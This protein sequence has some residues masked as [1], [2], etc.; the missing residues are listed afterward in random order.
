M[1]IKLKK[2]HCSKNRRLG[3]E[4][5]PTAQTFQISCDPTMIPKKAK[6]KQKYLE[7]NKLHKILKLIKLQMVKRKHT[8]SR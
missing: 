4:W 2:N 1:L 5:L 8:K 7:T 6:K 3:G